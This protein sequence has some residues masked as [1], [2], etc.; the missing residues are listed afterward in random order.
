MRMCHFILFQE[1][2][3]FYKNII[4]GK[5]QVSILIWITWNNNVSLIHP[6]PNKWL[7]YFPCQITFNWKKYYKLLSLFLYMGPFFPTIFNSLFYPQKN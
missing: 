2:K 7:V 5:C 1:V 4:V 3:V 6:P